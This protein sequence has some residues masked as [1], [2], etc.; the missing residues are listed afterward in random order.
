M[1]RAL[2]SRDRGHRGGNPG[3]QLRPRGIASCARGL[4]YGIAIGSER[5]TPL[6]EYPAAQEKREGRLG[7]D[8]VVALAILGLG[9]CDGKAH[10]LPQRA[11]DES[12]HAVGLPVRCFH[13][14]GQGSAIL[15][16]QQFEDLGRLAAVPGASGLLRGFGRFL[17]R[18]GLLAGLALL[19]R[20]VGALWRN[21][22]LFVG[23]W[24]LTAR[25]RLRGSGF[26]DQFSHFDFS[27][28]GDYRHDIHHSGSRG[29][30]LNSAGNRK[31]RWNGDDLGRRQQLAAFGI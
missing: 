17:G 21:A 27:F 11:A 9:G 31:R 29:K 18:A 10:L 22:G 15:A 12:P 14:L 19:R 30:Q 28:G 5:E 7:S 24:L 20:N 26:C 2:P 1:N 8:G 23:F 4:V 16:L 6:G 3:G 13:D 25:W